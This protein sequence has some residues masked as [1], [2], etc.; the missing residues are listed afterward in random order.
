MEMLKTIERNLKKQQE[1]TKEE[2]QF[3]KFSMLILVLVN[4]Q[5]AGVAQNATF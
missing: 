4:S 1:L 3:V 2:D 5:R